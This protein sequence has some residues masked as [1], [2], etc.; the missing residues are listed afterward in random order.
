VNEFVILLAFSLILSGCATHAWEEQ[1]DEFRVV[2]PSSESREIKASAEQFL[3]IQSAVQDDG[4]QFS[5]DT[6]TNENGEASID[7]LPVAI[8]VC[9]YAR[10]LR[11]EIFRYDDETVIGEVAVGKV[12]AE[13]V[14]KQRYMQVRLGGEVKLIQPVINMLDDLINRDRH[15]LIDT[16]KS[17]RPHVKVR[18][19]W[20]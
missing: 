7:L 9:F 10:D 6:T 20:E 19:V 3:R 5:E 16:L 17:L 12:E 18:E 2:G 15:P 1:T 14:L 11:L 8:M 4:F 13:E